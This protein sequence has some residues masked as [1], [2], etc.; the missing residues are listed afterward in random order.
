MSIVLE[1]CNILVQTIFELD[2]K[3]FFHILAARHVGRETH[4]MPNSHLSCGTVQDALT[5]IDRIQA[6]LCCKSDFSADLQVIYI[7]RLCV[8]KLLGPAQYSS[9]AERLFHRS[10]CRRPVKP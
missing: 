7:S 4:N 10:T 6:T 8:R 2:M 3:L 5:D 1:Y 9:S